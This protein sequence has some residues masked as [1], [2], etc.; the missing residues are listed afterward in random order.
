MQ[1]YAIGDVPNSATCDYMETC[2]YDC[3]P[4]LEPQP[5]TSNQEEFDPF[6]NYDTYNETFMLVNSD[7]II[8]KIKSLM[9]ERHF[10]TKKDLFYFINTPKKYPTVQIYAALTQMIDDST[11]YIMDKYNRT[12]YLIN[13]GDYYLFQPSELNYNHT[14]IYERSVPLD[15]KHT[16]IKFEINPDLSN[17]PA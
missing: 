14:S 17:Q 9:K 1:D 10:Y 3:L 11:E 2:T 12:G 5:A 13:I 4:H 8:Q 6:L 15:F 7:K 16:M